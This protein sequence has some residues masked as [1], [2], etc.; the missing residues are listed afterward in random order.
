ELLG[1]ELN[2]SPPPGPLPVDTDPGHLLL[3]GLPQARL[4]FIQARI[5]GVRCGIEIVEWTNVDRHPV[6]RRYQDPGSTVL[7]L[8]VRDLDRV[9]ATLTHAGVRP[10]TTGAVTPTF[11]D[12]ATN[13]KQRAVTVQDPD[14]H[15]IELVQTDPSPDSAV[16]VSSNV[17][18]IGLRLTVADLD[19]AVA[20]YR[21]ILGVEGRVGSFEHD[22][23]RMAVGGLAGT[24]EFRTATMP[25]PGSSQTLQ[26]IQFRGTDSRRAA[27][28]SRVEDPGSYRLQLTFRDIDA[29]LDAL[30][31]LGSRT[32]TAGGVPVTMRFG[33]RP[34][35]LAVV[36]DPNNLFL[37]VQQAPG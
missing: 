7:V 18:S 1:L 29:T 33:G 15:Y 3:H 2:P 30:R 12:G 37:I 31:A 28:P 16:A 5:P 8:T 35:R 17:I 14:G 11:V 25:I 23:M 20:Y 22:S 36:P 6:H 9:L 13:A 10:L 26:L 4:R 34:W 27:M 32:I 24:T 21:K 19:D